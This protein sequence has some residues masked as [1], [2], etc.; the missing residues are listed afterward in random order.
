MA[1]LPSLPIRGRDAQLA[2]IDE[3]LEQA[4]D[5]IGSVVVIEGGSGLGKTRLLQAAW[6]TA[7]CMA[8]R[9]GGGMA[10]PSGSHGRSLA[11]SALHR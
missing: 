4:R 6:I 10:G 8:F 3:R 7:E 2:V 11:R 1:A 5:G 9:A